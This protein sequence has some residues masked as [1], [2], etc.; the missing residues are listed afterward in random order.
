[1]REDVGGARQPSHDFTTARMIKVGADAFLVAVV[2]EVNGRFAMPERSETA[3]V[4]AAGR[5]FDL[6]YGRAEVAEQLSTIGSR[7]VLR[8]VNDRQ[9]VEY[10]RHPATTVEA[11]LR[12][13]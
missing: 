12:C 11:S 5:A 2:G 4:I 1:M 8:Q 9:S 7:D 10:C 13:E 6:D 3:T